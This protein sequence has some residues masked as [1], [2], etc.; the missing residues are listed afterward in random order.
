MRINKTLMTVLAAGSLLALAAIP[1]QAQRRGGGMNGGGMNHGGNNGNFHNGHFHNGHF[2]GGSHVN[3]FFGGFGYPFYYGYP[4]AYGY[5]PY[6]GYPYYGYPGNAYYS[7]DPQGVYQGRVANPPRST[8]DGGGKDVS[9][10]A[11]V[12][13]KLATTGYYHG[14]IDG[15][16]GDGTRRA[17]R[18]YQRANGLPVN[19]RIGDDLL[20]AMGLG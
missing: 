15:V 16:V 17:I 6:Y 8:N 11:R 4:Y 18:E 7:Y 2:H 5:Y 20:D 12:Q 3:F 13:R 9:M 10:T 1:A 19:G 14:E